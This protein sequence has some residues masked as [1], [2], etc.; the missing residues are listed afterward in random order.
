MKK[1]KKSL[2]IINFIHKTWVQLKAIFPLIFHLLFLLKF[3]PF[4]HFHIILLVI[5][6]L[7][8]LK[9]L[10]ILLPTVFSWL[11]KWF[12][13]MYDCLFIYCKILKFKSIISICFWAFLHRILFPRIFNPNIHHLFIL[14]MRLFINFILSLRSSPQFILFFCHYMWIKL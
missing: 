6:I 13:L 8:T 1:Y 7:I 5:I 11:S 2:S 10:I 4:I 9:I 3:I 14:F 12:I